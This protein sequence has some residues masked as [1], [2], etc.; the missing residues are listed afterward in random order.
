MNR[1][2]VVRHI[3]DREEMPASVVDQVLA[4]FFDT[5]GESLA[6]GH[7]ITIRRFGKFEPRL[8]RAV[9]RKNPKTG[10]PISVPEKTSVGF[11]PSHNLKARL[12]LKPRRRARKK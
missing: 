5:V 8:R 12:N 2:D 1:G 11:V 6:A 4:S 7:D 9:V 3:A 10:E